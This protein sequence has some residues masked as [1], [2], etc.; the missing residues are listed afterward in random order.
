MSDIK[1][2][3]GAGSGGARGRAQ[4]IE[5]RRCAKRGKATEFQGMGLPK[6]QMKALGQ[7][8]PSLWLHT[9]SEGSLSHGYLSNT[10]FWRPKCFHEEL[11]IG[12]RK[13]RSSHTTNYTR[14][15]TPMPPGL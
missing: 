11:Y 15:H 1:P 3:L 4:L 6:I 5:M 12:W 13:P 10:H 14:P 7:S 9:D 8:L 2:E